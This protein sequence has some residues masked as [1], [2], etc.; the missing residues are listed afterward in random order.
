MPH[1]KKHNIA[2]T[3][4]STRKTKVNDGVPLNTKIHLMVN[5]QIKK[6]TNSPFD[7]FTIIFF[8]T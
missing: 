1:N 3:E 5:I 2:H 4:N 8:R 6:D 7:T